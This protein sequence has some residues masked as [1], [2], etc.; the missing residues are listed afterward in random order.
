MLLTPKYDEFVKEMFRNETVRRY[1]ISDILKIPPENIRRIRLRNPFLHRHYH[2][3][4]QGIVDVVL[5]LNDCR[6]INI[7]LQVKVVQYW[8]KRQLFYLAKLYTEELIVG[9]SYEKLKKCIGISILDFNL[10]DRAQYHSV[11]RLRDEN[12]HEFTDVLELHVIELKKELT[13]DSEIENWIRFFNVTSEEDLKMIKTINPGILEAIRI[14]HRMNMR[15]PLRLRY[16]SYLKETRDTIAREDYIRNV[17]AAEAAAEG[18]AKGKAEGLA[19]GLAEGKA[20]GLAKGRAEG[21]AEG[22]AEGR[23]E[24]KSEGEALMAELVNRLLEDRRFDDIRLAAED[25]AARKRLYQEYG[26][27]R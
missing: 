27:G 18:L 23:S 10:T 5:E 3:Q 8:D 21:L 15:N 1:F 26:I 20:E 12:G 7:E 17:A 4:K 11:Y 2:R 24:G 9:D 13:G 22:L 14:L 6:K 25:E 19:K 16:E